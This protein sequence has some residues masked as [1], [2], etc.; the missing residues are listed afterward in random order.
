MTTQDVIG[1]SDSAQETRRQRAVETLAVQEG[2]SHEGLDRVTRMA[3]LALGVSASSITVLD[4]D[5]AWFPSIQGFPPGPMP[6]SETF[7]DRT[8]AEGETVLVPDA[9]QDPRF[10]HLQA[11]RDGAVRFYVGHPLR[12]HI[13]NVVGTFCVFGEEARTLDSEELTTFRD[14]AS[15]AEQ[16]LVSSAEMVQ[17]GRVQASMLPAQP[18][19]LPGWSIDGICMP[20]LSVGGDFYDF[21]L[22]D[23]VV[24][25]GLGDVMGKGT[26]AALVGAGVRAALRST[27]P[28]VTAGVDLGITATQA[29]RSLL[30]DLERAESFVTLFEAALDL[31]DGHLRY[32]DAGSG[33][34]LVRRADG[35]V[36]RL[37]GL[38]R[39]FGVLP[40]DHWTEH[41]TTVHPGDRLLVFSDGVL[42]L[43][44]DPTDWAPELGALLGGADDVATALDL[45]ARLTRARTPLDDVTGVVVY[46][47]R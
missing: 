24:H 46:R 8:H 20:A 19:V 36:E 44:D 26:G 45:L 11:V 23:G 14:L 27:H 29:A 6:R 37:S 1:A 40:D 4:G 3:R 34:A 17:A 47:D 13:G 38:D 30:P 15:W 25:L 32:V 21:G 2:S 33:L 7:C 5:R 35:G 10:A 22:S 9:T 41:Q 16:E 39:P 42:D 31:H 12:D 18:I 43:I 28:A